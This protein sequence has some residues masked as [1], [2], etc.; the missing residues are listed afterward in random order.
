[1]FEIFALIS[2]SAWIVSILAFVGGTIFCFIEGGWFAGCLYLFTY[3]L[4]TFVVNKMFLDKL[5]MAIQI[6]T[7]HT[8]LSFLFSAL[9]QF[10]MIALM[11]KCVPQN[12]WWIVIL[13]IWDVSSQPH[14]EILRIMKQDVICLPL[15]YLNDLDFRNRAVITSSVY[16][17]VSFL[18]SCLVSLVYSGILR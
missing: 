15:A 12:Y 3:T 7:K 18:L 1:M 9:I 4:M 13:M 16:T 5:T 14:Q 2:I 10:I 11:Y 17:N 6:V 8:R